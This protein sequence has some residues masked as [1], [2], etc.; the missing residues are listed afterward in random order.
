MKEEFSAVNSEL[1]HVLGTR[2]LE[3]S[4]LNA[5][6][7]DVSERHRRER[8]ELEEHLHKDKYT[9]DLCAMENERLRQA[10]QDFD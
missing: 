2:S 4:A 3:I 6:L 5:E 7:K 9:T 1:K 10:K 8:T